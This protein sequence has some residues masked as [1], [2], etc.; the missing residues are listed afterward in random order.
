MTITK[1]NSAATDV[2][3]YN[4]P[5]VTALP[6]MPAATDVR[7]HNLPGVTAAE[8]RR[9]VPNAVIWIDGARVQ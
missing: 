4:L 7:L 3:L 6:D 1:I 5:G 9:G 2:Q 8:A